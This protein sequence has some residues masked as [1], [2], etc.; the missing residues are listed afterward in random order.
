MSPPSGA[1]AGA[2]AGAGVG[3]ALSPPG[4]A[5]ALGVQA[6]PPPVS[7]SS[8]QVEVGLLSPDGAPLASPPGPRPLFVEADGFLQDDSGVDTLLVLGEPG[9]GKSVFTWLCAQRCV[10]AY[11]AMAGAGAGA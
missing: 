5:A 3:T 1:G 9:M 4:A 7:V 8:P 6:A 11:N 2:G 10:E